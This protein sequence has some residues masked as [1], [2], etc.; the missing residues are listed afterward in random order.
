MFLST[1][2]LAIIFTLNSGKMASVIINGS[3]SMGI[4]DVARAGHATMHAIRTAGKVVDG[5]KNVAIGKKGADGERH[6]GMLQGGQAIVRAGGNAAGLFKGAWSSSKSTAA[7][8]RSAIESK[9]MSGNEGTAIGEGAAA[10]AKTIGAAGLQKAKDVGYKLATGKNR[11]HLGKDGSPDKDRFYGM[12]ERAEHESGFDGRT[13]ATFKDVAKQAVQAG[14][15]IAKRQVEIAKAKRP[16]NDGDENVKKVAD[17]KP[18]H[19]ES[20]KDLHSRSY[21]EK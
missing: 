5:V 13:N 12:G 9:E 10:F 18:G 6:G 21:F 14:E 1:V 20:I 11:Q 16:R 3:P 15:S 17:T 2:A 4:G 19:A 8:V 7:D